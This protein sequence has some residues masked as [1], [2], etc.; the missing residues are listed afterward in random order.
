VRI[1]YVFDQVLPSSATDTEQV[2]N[3]VAALGRR[4]VD[5]TLVLPEGPRPGPPDADA[6]REYYQVDGPFEVM[7]LR[8]YPP[9]RLRLGEKVGHAARAMAEPRLRGFDVVY[10]R[11]VPSLLAG[12]LARHPVVYETYRPWPDQ[13]PLVRPAFR[14]AMSRPNFLGGVFH[15]EF[16]RGCYERL[17]VPPHK[18][19]VV[20]NGYDPSR[21]DPPT[22][23]AEAR[24]SLGL[25]LDGPLATYTG[26][27]TLAKGLGVVLD[28]ARANP[29]VRFLFVGSE[30]FGEF[31]AQAAALPNVEVRGWARFDELPTYLFAS[32]VLIIPPSV[33]PLESVG[34]TVLPMK[35]FLYLAAGRPI[36]APRSPDT[37]ELLAHDS[38][39]WLV[40][41][42]DPVAASDAVARLCADPALAER[43]SRAARET[44]AA[45]TWDARAE[46][47][48]GHLDAWLSAPRRR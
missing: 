30:R 11:N 10:T 17:G 44:A 36:L 15:S 38:N 23:R 43:L 46:R 34:N 13:R 18:L 22:P 4:G 48:A 33:G 3:T 41:A 24:A 32:D 5:V 27:V 1:A 40:P 20:H 31:E 39:A 6:L 42:D 8:S 21:F 26:R 19:A 2:L 35:L 28:M 14:A 25:A 16:A 7:R 45:L 29:Q 12:V 37:A 47:L 9:G